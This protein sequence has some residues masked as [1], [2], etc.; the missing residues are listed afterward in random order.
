MVLGETM[1]INKMKLRLMDEGGNLIVEKKLLN[2][3]VDE[4]NL[5]RMSEEIFGDPEP[6]MIHRSAVMKKMY[7]E[8]YDYLGERLE[9]G[10]SVTQWREI[11]S[12]IRG[13]FDQNFVKDTSR[14]EVG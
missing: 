1:K 5:L 14:I 4:G 3:P 8:I 11:P 7:S 13:Y 6:C 2:T 10:L 12:H 9:Q